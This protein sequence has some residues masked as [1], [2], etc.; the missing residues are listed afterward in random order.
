MELRQFVSELKSRK[1]YR[2]AA[3]YCA[4]AWAFLLVSD[5][6]FPVVGLPDW[7]VTAV[8]V[9]AA[10]G[11]PLALILSWLFEL[12]PEGQGAHMAEGEASA[13]MPFSSARIIE[14]TVV[15]IL[16]GLVGYLYVG[17][18]ANP[19]DTSSIDPTIADASIAVMPFVNL[20]EDEE[21]GQPR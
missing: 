4:G 20:S 2:T 11:F 9:I 14:L 16:C 6:I 13:E 18:L 15:L 8:L 3:V 12:T 5:I 1:V 21:L 10:L 7:T 17:R 19:P